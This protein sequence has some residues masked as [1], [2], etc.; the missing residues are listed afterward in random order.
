M[1]LRIQIVEAG[2]L[3]Q[4]VA[5]MGTRCYSAPRI[6]KPRLPLGFV[7]IALG[8]VDGCSLGVDA[9]GQQSADATAD[10]NAAE[11]AFGH[12]FGEEE[13]S[14]RADDCAEQSSGDDVSDEVGHVRSLFKYCIF[15][16]HD[17]PAV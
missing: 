12:A 16:A 5:L 9:C 14:N 3:S 13:E 17:G 8:Q 6:A 11:E 1:D 10:E 4:L 15:L 7:G 2:G